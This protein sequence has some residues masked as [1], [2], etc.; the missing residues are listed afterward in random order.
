MS[1]TQGFSRIPSTRV[2][3]AE[4]NLRFMKR[5]IIGLAT[6]VVVSGSAGLAGLGLAG[7]AQ[8]DDNVG[9]PF[10]WCPGDDMIYSPTATVSG[11]DNGPGLA[12]SWDMNICHT[13]YRLKDRK[14]NVPYKG[15]LPSD[16]WDGDNPPAG[17][18]L[19]P[20]PPC[21]PSIL[22]CL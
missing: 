15:S 22:P 3:G 21:A 5:L 12:Y 11:A 7:I 6:T 2:A 16:V 10:H 9:G 8:A 17:S 4:N 14:G 18:V 1:Q 13:W 19:A 20:L